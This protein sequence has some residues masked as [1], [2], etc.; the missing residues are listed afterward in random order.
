MEHDEPEVDHGE[1]QI[2][3]EAQVVRAHRHRASVLH[4][5]QVNLADCAF[6]QKRGGID[7]NT[8]LI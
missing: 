4:G 2:E 5:V 8:A 6:V 3:K 7:G 1:R